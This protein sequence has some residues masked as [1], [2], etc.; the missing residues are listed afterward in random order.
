MIY[1]LTSREVK[2]LSST[3]LSPLFAHFN[4][5]LTGLG[6]IRA[7]RHDSRF[8]RDNENF[9]EANQKT[10]FASI[11]AGQWLSLRLQMIGVIL[12]TGVSIMAVVQ[13]QYD[14]VNPGLIGLVITYTL[15]ITSYLSSIVNAFTET[16]RE[17]IAVERIKQYFEE[18]PIE[19][20]D[21]ENPP[22]GWP[23]QGVIEF[24]RVVLKYR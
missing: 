16:E 1:R 3:S 23:S 19:Y 11:S 22:Y 6:I 9:L 10:N 12:L 21:G 17:M 4:E 2:R 14:I 18:I 13:H 15:S 8:E 24:N 7:F 20:S 5:T